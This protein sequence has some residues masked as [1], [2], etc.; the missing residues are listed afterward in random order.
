M[1]KVALIY[2]VVCRRAYFFMGTF[3]PV[4]LSNMKALA[5]TGYAG[6]H[7]YFRTEN[8]NRLEC[9]VA[10][11]SKGSLFAQAPAPAKRQARGSALPSDSQALRGKCTVR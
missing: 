11:L 5:L 4:T 6:E 8:H 2:G 3:N 7:G 9:A 1:P 10:R